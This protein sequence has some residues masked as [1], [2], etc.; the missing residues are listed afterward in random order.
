M[1]EWT[2]P[3]G[4]MKGTEKINLI[5]QQ[6]APPFCDGDDDCWNGADENKFSNLF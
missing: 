1:T 6:N 5:K 3:M 4:M 2:A